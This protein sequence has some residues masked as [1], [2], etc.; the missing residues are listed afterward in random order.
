LSRVFVLNGVNLGALGTRQPEVYGN[1]TLGDMERLLRVEFPNVDLEFR[2]TDFE[3]EMVRFVGEAAGSDG[4]IINP[5]AWTHY[6]YALHDALEA[7]NVPK[8]EVHLS[9]IHTRE[10][11]RRVSVI[12]PSVDAVVAGMGPGGYVAAVGYVLMRGAGRSQGST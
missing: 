12:S 11:W 2:Q 5:G 8:V 3:G 1:L 7:T 9:N 10:E 6:S 4:L